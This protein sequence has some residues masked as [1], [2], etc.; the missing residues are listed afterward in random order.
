MS[1]STQEPPPDV[2]PVPKPRDLKPDWLAGI[3]AIA[4]S[5]FGV[6]A[7]IAAVV[8][9]KQNGGGGSGG[10]VTAGAGPATA[11][12][13]SEFSISP[14]MITATPSGGLDITNAG[15][16]SHNLAVQGTTLATP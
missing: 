11:V 15:K 14:E 3:G 7:L 12:M 1:I 10:S 6:I 4:L 8:V 16:V 5:I 13:L 9:A 2:S